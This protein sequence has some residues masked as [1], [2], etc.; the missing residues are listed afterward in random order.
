[1][2][3]LLCFGAEAWLK[4]KSLLCH[5][6]RVSFEVLTQLD[7]FLF[8][9]CARKVEDAVVLLEKEKKGTLENQLQIS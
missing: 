6:T 7:A 1:M 3:C 4:V 5:E 2:A 9:P 8:G